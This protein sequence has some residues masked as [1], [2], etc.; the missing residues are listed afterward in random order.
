M[1]MSI[2]RPQT[3]VIGRMLD[4]GVEEIEIDCR[5]WQVR[6]PELTDYR[7]EAMN[8]KGIVYLPE[9]VEMKDGRLIWTIMPSDTASEGEGRYQIVAT[10]KNGERKTSMPCATIIKGIMPGTAQ[11]NPP[12]PAQPWVDKVMGAAERA[13]N[14]AERAESVEI[15]GGIQT[16]NGKAPDE[17]GNVD[18]KASDVDA[19]PTS[20]GEVD[21]DVTLGQDRVN[22]AGRGLHFKRRYVFGKQQ[23]Y[24]G[25][26]DRNSGGRPN[27]QNQTPSTLRFYFKHEVTAPGT[28]G[29]GENITEMSADATTFSKPVAFTDN[30]AA[31]TTRE[32]LD[33]YS[34]DETA[35][36]IAKAVA[37]VESAPGKTAYQYAQDGG[38]T[39]TEAE[40]AE[41]MAKEIPDVDDTLTQEGKAAD[42]KATGDVIGE[43]SKEIANVGKPTDEQVSEAVNAYLEENPMDETVGDELNK[44]TDRLYKIDGDLCVEFE[45]GGLSGADYKEENTSAYWI[46]SKKY[47][48]RE[49]IK[50]ASVNTAAG[51]GL[52]SRH[53]DKDMNFVG[54]NTNGIESP[55]SAG[56]YVRILI[57]KSG[58]V[59]PESPHGFSV[60]STADDFSK[61]I[62]AIRTEAS[63]SNCV[64]EMEQGSLAHAGGNEVDASH[65]IRNKGFIPYNAAYK[66]TA[67]PGYS[68]YVFFFDVDKKQTK[69]SGESYYYLLPVDFGEYEIP[70]IE[71]AAYI[72]F[73]IQNS[74]K[75][76]IAPT[77]DH[78]VRLHGFSRYRYEH[79]LVKRNF[80]EAIKYQQPIM[81]ACMGITSGSFYKTD[82][83]AVCIADLHGVYHPME[84]AHQVREDIRTYNLGA[85]LP[86]LNAGDMFPGRAKENGAMVSSYA[87]YIEKATAYGVYHTI[88]QH[89]V[90]FYD[91][92]EGRSKANCLTHDEVFEKFIAPMKNVW[93][94]SDLTTN[95]YYKD[96]VNSNV[97]LISL[98]QYNIPLVEETSDVWAYPRAAVWYG[99]EQLDWFVNALSS[100]PEGYRIVVLMHQPEKDIVKTDNGIFFTGERVGGGGIIDGTP[101]VD[102]VEAYKTKASLSKTYVCTDK[103]RYPESDFSNHVNADFSGAKGVFGNYITGDAH[104][105]YV[106]VVEDTQ[107]ANI[108]ITSSGQS[109]DNVILGRSYGTVAAGGNNPESS[110]V[111]IL[112]YDFNRSLIR[113]GRLGQQFASDGKV[114]MYTAISY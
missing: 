71:N 59:S 62:A 91:T 34:R 13:E 27:Q 18:L 55:A 81:S 6:Y 39:G 48:K 80:L 36:A 50:S 15:G 49:L 101:I 76:A 28:S 112:G 51:Y 90:G 17:D 74:G 99:Q 69:I 83:G 94:L 26:Y 110:I 8:P 92:T 60:V 32:N 5:G 35:K 47:Y 61:Q 79:N 109:H 1:V 9:R 31:G 21:G 70:Y 29:G 72:R 53:Y 3:I 43:L 82:F 77:D 113:I 56:V 87:E 12:E 111:T 106:G 11:E 88:G 75:T 30:A 19:L 63:M 22:A 42:A 104:I 86:I 97:R 73:S 46:R 4:G 96:F 100:T 68:G 33:V 44:I 40:F 10:G 66:L 103:T 7:V 2:D 105:D 67:N 25:L 58:G 78:G 52:Q 23:A 95:Y 20:G 54:L 57:G 93:G 102:I 37:N 16:V 14:A 41:M 89:E 107:Q 85:D 64:V 65:Y 45:Q 38:Y 114:R 84:D 108:G 98:Y 24:V